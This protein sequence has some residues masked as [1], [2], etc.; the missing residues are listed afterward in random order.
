MKPPAD[1][2]PAKRVEAS[3]R[4]AF[5]PGTIRGK[6][7][8]VFAVIVVSALIGAIAAQRANVLV[9]QQL[10][11]ITQDN[12]P[13]LVTAH[14]VA[15]A[16]TN[17]R[18][19]AAAM[20]T[21]RDEDVLATRREVLSRQIDDAKAIVSGLDETG[22]DEQTYGQLETLM[23]E[24]EALTEELAAEVGAK[25]RLAERLNERVQA[26]A[27]AHLRFNES[28]RPL[29]ERELSFLDRTADQVIAGTRDAVGLLNEISFRGL[30]PVLSVN[31]QL[32]KMEE[33]LRNGAQAPDERVLDEAWGAFV[34]ASSVISRNIDVL[35]STDAVTRNVDIG[36]LAE[37][38]ERLMAFG[39]GDGNVFDLR[40]REL[41]GANVTSASVPGGFEAD[42]RDF[43]RFLQRSITLIR[44]ETVT[45]GIDLDRAITD[46]LAAMNA[47]S[48]DGY[49][50]LLKLEAFA[51][52]SVGVL[53]VGA[54][55]RS[56]DDLEPL[57]REYEST[58]AE[59][60][61]VLQRMRARQD[62]SDAVGLARGMTAFG[63]GDE[64]ILQLR[65]DVLRAEGLVGLLLTRTNSANEE[66]SG[67][68]AD[69]VAS[70]QGRADT[71][72]A[73]VLESL[74]ASRLT[75]VLALG[76][77]LL[78]MLGAI[79]Y[80]NRSLGSRLSAFSKSAIALA[81]GDL[82][83]KLPEPAGQ[84]EVSRLM[85]ALAVFRDTAAEMEASNLRELQEARLRL[86][87]AIESIQEGFALFD[88]DDRLLLRN[89]RYAELLYDNEAVP[90]PGASYEEILRN[91]VRRGL[92]L[93]IEGDPE[94]WVEERIRLH[95]EPGASQQQR[96]ANGRWIRINERHTSDGGT[97]VI[98]SDI[99]ALRERQAQL[100]E[101]DSLKSSFLSSVSHEL[102]TPLTSVRGFAKLI[103]R[104]FERYFLPEAG[105]AKLESRARRIVE[106][107]GI[108]QNESER[109]TRLINDV[110]DLSKIEAGTTSWN[111]TAFSIADL[112]RSAFK[113]A[114]GQFAD[115]PRIEPRLTL[116]DPLPEVEADYDRVFQIVINLI[117]N[118]VKFTESGVIEVS[119]QALP[120][121]WVE[122]A[123]RDTGAGI[124]EGELEKIF[125]KFH[126]AAR[127]DTLSDKPTGT[128]LGLS[129]CKQIVEHYG[130]EIWVESV[131]GEGSR[132]VFTLP[133]LGGQKRDDGVGAKRVLVV[134]DDSATRR[135]LSQ[136]LE[137]AGYRVDGCADGAQ[138]LRRIRD[139]QPDLITIDLNMPGVDGR[140]VIA[141]VRDDPALGKM[142][143]VVVSGFIGSDDP[144]GDVALGKPV[145]EDK[146]LE[147]IRLLLSEPVAPSS[148]GRG[149][150]RGDYLLVDL[151]GR[152]TT[153]PRVPESVPQFRRCALAELEKRL[154]EG[155]SGTLVI[156]AEAIEDVDLAAILAMSRVW[157]V[158]IETA[159]HSL[160][161]EEP[162]R[163]QK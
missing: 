60:S 46:S 86:D 158:L 102:R 114:S 120:E 3:R 6:L 48:V 145:D 10:S 146:L 54:F 128:G 77:S 75:L 31:A 98:Y 157:G 57:Y 12:L 83:V 15:S 115:K 109:L 108:V 110:L 118:A 121:G 23:S 25:L 73:E 155:F 69:I 33:A 59:F 138:A 105:D 85:R 24:V 131:P 159:N 117:N 51:N 32:V 156:P 50:A 116:P 62:L 143:I 29:V 148:K 30:I 61:S 49:G 123:V 147:S 1:S 101:M 5:I 17:I 139:W 53:T 162:T 88:A 63:E 68:A 44:G 13:A 37:R 47:A 142:P 122:I 79:L 20:A 81:E 133:V 40:R 119:A 129:I 22:I 21:S 134:E 66:M 84:D 70:A 107:I 130:G 38:F 153:L 72:A 7:F 125:D 26:L 8:L 82:S 150:A 97:V 93:D 124:P 39:A 87:D 45:I 151:P 64:G 149:K 42:F 80:V 18:R 67:I 103:R 27:A 132:F 135:Y 127:Q 99:T 4:W 91:A 35:E 74:Q 152:Q 43:E 113:T 106:N 55:A 36:E 2:M 19:V 14:K 137:E 41:A 76:L 56:L 163:S 104:D 78:A 154:A 28:I 16:T 100:E 89:S 161:Q 58:D 96:R 136:V 34:E 65:G 11:Q 112:L 52:R 160:I 111:D 95:R 9:Q 141:E 144:G 71:A 94:Q 92:I 140:T 90:E 126:Q